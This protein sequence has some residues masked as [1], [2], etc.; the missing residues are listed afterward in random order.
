M[1]TIPAATLRWS[2]ENGRS[3]GVAAATLGAI[4][5]SVR[6]MAHPNFLDVLAVVLP[7]LEV[8]MFAAVFAFYLDSE[9]EKRNVTFGGNFEAMVAWFVVVGV[10]TWGNIALVRYAILAYASLGVP[11]TWGAPY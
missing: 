3:I 9:T 5:V 7:A 11:P 10:I 4:F 2:L 8:A 1:I 6:G